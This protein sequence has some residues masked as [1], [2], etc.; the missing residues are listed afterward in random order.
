[1]QLAIYDEDDDL[2]AHL[3]V[4]AARRRGHTARKIENV[5]DLDHVFPIPPSAIILGVPMLDDRILGRL[6][7]IHDTHEQS[8]IFVASEDAGRSGTLSALGRGAT[9]VIF[10]PVVPSDL[11]V[12]AEI[13]AANRGIAH[14]AEERVRIADLEVD[15]GRALAVKAGH[16]LILTRIELRLLYCLAQHRGQ[17]AT[18]DRLLTFAW[19]A[20]DQTSSTLKT[21]ISHLRQKLAAAG[22]VP[23]SIRS[24]QMLGYVLDV[25][26]HE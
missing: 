3:V 19:E 17:V 22:G 13:A 14:L 7:Q 21:H 18:T 23:I 1:M 10:K 15:V 2:F 5:S 26:E 20:E 8:L 16:D 12:R 11:I 9:D 24:R 25:M 6:G 4:A